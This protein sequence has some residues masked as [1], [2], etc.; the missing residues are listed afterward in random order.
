MRH[1]VWSQQPEYPV[2]LLVGQIQKDE[3]D[4]AY[5]PAG[6]AVDRDDV[7]VLDLHF[8]GK[9]TPA[10][11]MQRY[12]KEQLQ[13]VLDEN[14]VQYI[15]VTDSSYFKTFTGANKSDA[16][17][18]YVLDSKFGTQKVLYIPSYRAMF[19]DPAGIRKKI[20]QSLDALVAHATGSYTQPGHGIIKS[21]AYPQTDSEIEAWLD[22]LIDMDVPLSIDI[23]TFGL[24][25]YNAGIGTISFAWNQGEGIAFPV[26]YVPIEGATEAP[27]GMQVRNEHRRVLLRRFFDRLKQ[28]A[29]YHR[30]AFDVYVLI[31][32]LYMDS[33]ID[34]EGL[35]NGVEVMLRN[36]DC[37][38]LITYLAT[39]SCAGNKPATM[40]RPRST[41]SR[42]SR[43]RSCW[44]T[45][46]WTVSPPGS[47]ST[48]TTRRWWP[49]TS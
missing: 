2:C 1:H 5:F 27:F 6:S 34:T 40:R 28:K 30:I 7:M 24:K 36:W 14:K 33:I 4:R 49:T 10:S 48:R 45:T 26:D 37:T 17:L 46:W 38:L 44:N 41:T 16:N 19:A 25:H 20:G 22:K 29:M 35:L 15:L 39:N 31:Y 9:K 43:C 8:T 3:I 12:I 11:E 47:R 23:E 13:E 21:A 42:R 18:G 32:Q